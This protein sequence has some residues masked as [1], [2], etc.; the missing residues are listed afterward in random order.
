MVGKKNHS[1]KAIRRQIKACALMPYL[2]IGW[3]GMGPGLAMGE[4]LKGLVGSA[5]ERTKR[6][7]E[8]TQANAAYTE[9][10]NLINAGGSSK[11]EI[12][13]A[14]ARI[15]KLSQNRNPYAQNIHGCLISKQVKVNSAQLLELFK[16]AAEAGVP[17]AK[18]NYGLVL[19]KTNPSMGMVAI[20]KAYQET[21]LEQA[22]VRLMLSALANG[23]TEQ[24]S[25]YANQL[26]L[27]GNPSALFVRAKIDFL[28]KN[29]PSSL[30]FAKKA[31][32]AYEPNAP[33]LL[34]D[35]YQKGLGVSVDETQARA[36]K[37]IYRKLAD[38][39]SGPYLNSGNDPAMAIANRWLSSHSPGKHIEYQLP[40]CQMGRAV[41]LS[42]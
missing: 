15:E 14:W 34:A 6:A 9:Y 27:I 32:E 10:L 30:E 28:A 16:G 35:L 12:S 25:R 31:V 3:L 33:L 17:I 39:N 23:K 42:S 24:A 5:Q 36:W 7:N 41:Q 8:E 37:Y 11:A 20:S 4:S 1:M 2:C 22:G 13:T 21:G 40:L 29:Y 18:Y 38:I 26:I 19:V